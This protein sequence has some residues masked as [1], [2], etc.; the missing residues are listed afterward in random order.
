[1]DEGQTCR[2]WMVPEGRRHTEGGVVQIRPESSLPL[3]VWLVVMP[4][5]P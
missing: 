1:M 4:V 3:M 2:P 5:W